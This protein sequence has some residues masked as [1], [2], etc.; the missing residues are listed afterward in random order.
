VTLCKISTLEKGQQLVDRHNILVRKGQ[1]DIDEDNRIIEE[2][3]KYSAKAM[4]AIKKL[5]TG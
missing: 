5:K 4:K 2:G 1:N 3:K